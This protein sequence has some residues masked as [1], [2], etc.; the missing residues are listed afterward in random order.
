MIVLK[1]HILFFSLCLFGIIGRAEQ[2]PTYE[3]Y[4]S[5]QQCFNSSDGRLMFLD[6]GK[7]EPIVLLHGIPTSGW[8][9]RNM[10][11]PLVDAGFRVIVPDMLGCGSSDNPEGNTLF[12][13]KAHAKRLYELMRYLKIDQWTQVVHD[14]G[15]LWTHELVK[16]H[17]QSLKKLVI[18]NAYI[19]PQ[20]VDWSSRIG[21]G[22]MAKVNL[23]FH[24][25]GLKQHTFASKILKS[26]VHFSPEKSTLS[27]YDSPLEAGKT[28]SIFAH[29]SM[30]LQ[31]LVHAK[32][33]LDWIPRETLIIWGQNDPVL[34]WDSQSE[35]VK[36]LTGISNDRIHLLNAGHLIQEEKPDTLVQI[37][38]DF[39]G[40][41]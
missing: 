31:W 6:E 23:A 29:E 14:A 37:I 36:S 4:Q 1:K 33:S 22:F 26:S 19:L 13:P 41:R 35:A 25:I 8:S 18:L 11:Q 30:I 15:S 38:E 3:D 17:P 27:G 12:T 24:K 21:T 39:I 40:I 7:G 28:E 10:V 5:K 20:G 2:Y 32:P 34:K 9:Y 16:K